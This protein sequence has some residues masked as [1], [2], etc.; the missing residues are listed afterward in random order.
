MKHSAEEVIRKAIDYRSA[1]L[2]VA[3]PGQV[4]SFDPST[5]TVVV[6]PMVDQ[7]LEADD[8]V[9]TEQVPI[10]TGVPVQFPAGGGYYVSMP[11]ATG[12]TGLIVFSDFSMDYWLQTGQREQTPVQDM[13]AHSPG[14]AVFIPG[15]FPTNVPG[16]AAVTVNADGSVLVG[17]AATAPVAREGDAVQVTIPASSLTLAVSGGSATGPAAPLTLSGTITA[18]SAV[19]KAA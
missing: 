16:I 3:L 14:S 15:V 13:R 2:R 6:Q 10:L 9:I 11:I 5:K 19:V 1:Q 18:G 17:H 12:D 8:D 4:Q 7:T